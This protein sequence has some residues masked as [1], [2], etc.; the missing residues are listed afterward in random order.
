MC[1]RDRSKKWS[2]SELEKGSKAMMKVKA[3]AEKEHDLEQ[4]IKD[5]LTSCRIVFM[6]FASL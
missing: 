5:T 1:I 2:C 3:E 6:C 4:K